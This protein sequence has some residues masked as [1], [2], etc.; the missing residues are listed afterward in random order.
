VIGKRPN[1]DLAEILNDIFL[2]PK[3]VLQYLVC[4]FSYDVLSSSDKVSQVFIFNEKNIFKLPVN[5][6]CKLFDT[7]LRPILTY[8]C[9][10][11]YM[12]DSLPIYRALII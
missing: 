4:V 1:S 9:E 12:E 8:N 6:S 11:W 5:L 2:S 3:I 10:I 7:P